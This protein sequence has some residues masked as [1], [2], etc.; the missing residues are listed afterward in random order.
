MS[1]P[2]VF[3][4]PRAADAPVDPGAYADF[5]DDSLDALRSSNSGATRPAY[6][7]DGTLWY[8]EVDQLL[9][10]VDQGGSPV[11]DRPVAVQ[12]DVPASASAPGVV[13]QVSWDADYLYVCTGVDAWKRVAIATW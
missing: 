8:D 10:L 13:G 12:A 6:A 7:V 9:L 1:Q 3:G 4:A 2:A 5:V 11:V